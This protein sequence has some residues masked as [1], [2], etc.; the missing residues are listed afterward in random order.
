MNRIFTSLIKCRSLIWVNAA[1]LTKLYL[2]MLCFH[3]KDYWSV[4]VQY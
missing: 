2:E 4:S 1:A 3:N